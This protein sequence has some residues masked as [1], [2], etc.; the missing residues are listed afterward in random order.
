[1][2]TR[3]AA[4]VFL[5]AATIS[6]VPAGAIDAPSGLNTAATASPTAPAVRLHPPKPPQAPTISQQVLAAL[7]AERAKYGV[8]P[9]VLDARLNAAAD[10][11]SRDQAARSTMSHTGAD[12]SNAGQRITGAGFAWRAWGE[13][14]AFGYTSATAVMQG[15]MNSPGHRANNLNGAFTHIGV[16]LAYSSNDT[17]YWTLVLAAPF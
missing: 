15:W 3:V 14:V 17:P 12:G 13:N 10:G 16:G 8:A 1:M 6:S 11:H 4:A 2:R 7:N 5:V 9:V